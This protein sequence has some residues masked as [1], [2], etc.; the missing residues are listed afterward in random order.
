MHQTEPMGHQAVPAGSGDLEALGD[1]LQ[2]AFF[3]D[4][5]M[6]WILPDEATRSRRLAGMF[7]ILLRIHYLPMHTVWTTAEQS[8]AALW[9]PPG[10][11][12]VPPG[13]IARALPALL[14]SL[15]R[16][17][18]RALRALDHV[19]RQHPEGPPHWYLGVLGTGPAHQG[20]G[21]GSALM[22]PV[23]ERCDR[24]G[25]PAF[26]ESSKESNIAFY[27]RF[28]FV[29]TGTTQL[30]F[31]GPTVWPMWREPRPDCP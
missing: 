8:G 1:V 12:R 29:V 24:E 5:V 10:H 31:G 9:S 13:D 7:G 30:P 27:A 21:V 15:G 18:V 3:D 2:A 28:G 26:L 4:P 25:V 16:H 22:A 20:Q 11:W 23:L 19:E 14:R 6:S 17:S